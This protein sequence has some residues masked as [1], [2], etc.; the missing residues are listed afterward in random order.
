VDLQ[1]FIVGKKFIVKEVV[2]LKKGVLFTSHLMS[3]NFLTK[4]EKYYTSW[5]NAYHHGLQWE[6]G[7]IP[8][9]V[10]T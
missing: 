7:M 3:W 1:G 2:V 4:S 9:R 6:D 8:L 5:L 10:N